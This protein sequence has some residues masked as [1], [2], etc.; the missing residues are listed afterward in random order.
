M[1]EAW[2]SE[3]SIKSKVDFEANGKQ[4]GFLRLPHSVHRSA[5]GWIPIPMTSIK[6]GEGPTLVIMA[7]NHGDEYEGQIA[8]S[9]LALL[10]GGV[11]AS[12]ADVRDAM[13]FAF[14]HFTI[15][16][17]PGAVVGLAAVL[18]GQIA[19]RNRAVATIITGG[20]V[21]LAQFSALTGGTE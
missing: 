2:M 3:T 21:D 4:S 19:I 9:N 6:N 20:N 1:R 15:V 18:N 13:R 11:T 12:D 10:A 5:Y 16:T 14:E 17:E 7:G 8:I